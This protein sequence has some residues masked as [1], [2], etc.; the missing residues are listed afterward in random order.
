MTGNG[1]Q[2]NSGPG[3]LGVDRREFMQTVGAAGVLGAIGGLPMSPLVGVASASPG[4]DGI[5]GGAAHGTDGLAQ[6]FPVPAGLRPGAQLDSRFPVSYAIPVSEGLRLMIEFFTALNQRDVQAIASTLHFPFAIYEN[7]EPL[8]FQTEAEFIANPPP[9][10]NGTG[11]GPSRILAGSYDM[12]ESVDVH[13][14]CPVGG[15]FSIRF[16]RYTPSGHKLLECEGIYSV[17]NN[18]GRWAIQLAS[19]I[20]HEVDFI[21]VKYPDAEA[22][23]IRGSQN[24]LAAFGYGEE[25]LLNTPSLGRGSYEPPLPLGTRTASV[26]FGYGP[27]ER[28]RDAREGRPLE[29]WVTR[30]VT[31]RLN[32][33]T[34][35]PT[36][37][38]AVLNTNL[39]EFIDLAGGAV[40]EY[41]Y[42]RDRPIRPI[43]I[44]ATHDKAHTYGGYLRYTAAGEL[45]SET[46]SVG[47]RIY[48]GGNWGS[49]GS[50]G[51]VTHHD[52]SNSV[53]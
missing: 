18:D 43:V 52:R 33:S 39:P 31:S 29:G 38:G 23:D 11:R 25:E 26:N 35:G 34:R 20:F 51:Q 15:A 7:I 36:P 46:R 21:G 30:G 44:H 4:P 48:T 5:A 49:G 37:E 9:T 28:S 32:V 8:V 1:E 19:T 22:A 40:G 14:Y 2:R 13:L 10:L 45:I 6:E 42:T 16:S 50:L 12:L 53:G 47:I 27:R 41:S 3:R 24:Y 17:T